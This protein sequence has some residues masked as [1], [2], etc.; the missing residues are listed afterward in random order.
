MHKIKTNQI[1]A[2][3]TSNWTIALILISFFIFSLPVVTLADPSLPPPPSGPGEPADEDSKHPYVPVHD[4]ELNL[5]FYA[6]HVDFNEFAENFNEYRWNFYD[7]WTD[8]LNWIEADTDSLKNLLGGINPE[9]IAAEECFT[10]TLPSAIP[11]YEIATV[12]DPDAYTNDIVVANPDLF[13]GVY[14][15]QETEVNASASLRCLLQELVEWRKLDLNLTI[16]KMMKD[17]IHDAQSFLFAKQLQ[18]YIVSGI[19][20]HAESGV[21]QQLSADKTIYAST[22]TPK[23]E[24]ELTKMNSSLRQGMV[25]Q[26]LG[27]PDGFVPLDIYPAF[28]SPIANDLAKSTLGLQT[29]D[30]E[31]LPSE[32]ESSLD[33]VFTTPG[34][35]VEEQLAGDFTVA[36]WDGF[37]SFLR[38]ENN[39]ITIVDIADRSLQN[40]VQQMTVDQYASMA[41]GQGFVDTTICID[42][43]DPWC[44]IR[45]IVTPAFI[46]QRTLAHTV[47][48]VGGDALTQSDEPGEKP[49]DTSQILQ[50]D[51]VATQ[52]LREYDPEELMM[53]SPNFNAMYIEFYE[54]FELGYFDLQDSTRVWGANALSNITDELYYQMIIE[55]DGTF[56]P[57][58]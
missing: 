48:A 49:S 3:K 11:F 20:N 39:P 5:Q 17:F 46:N 25:S 6:Y 26:I 32:L 9:G 58:Y 34:T 22:Y 55:N 36:G 30:I 12:Q 1:I 16:H 27:N 10:E 56:G 37:G 19:M 4:M 54:Q 47:E 38:P 57:E 45:Q 51:I 23:L 42:E 13:V 8:M 21:P 52:S 14:P 24:H 53:S 33:T 28:Q 29:Y 7:Y 40:Q 43:L 15:T 44:R 35:Y 18:S 50:T 2:T 31:M 41:A